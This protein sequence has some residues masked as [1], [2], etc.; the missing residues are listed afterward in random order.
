LVYAINIYNATLEVQN[1]KSPLAS[2]GTYSAITTIPILRPNEALKTNT[3]IVGLSLS[4]AVD[5][6]TEVRSLD[7]LVTLSLN[8]TILDQKT[9]YHNSQ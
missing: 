5:K 3:G 4:I 9:L 1:I 2:K 6:M 7:Y 8:G